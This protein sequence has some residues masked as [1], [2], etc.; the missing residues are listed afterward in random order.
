MANDK[1]AEGKE[2]LMNKNEKPGCFQEHMWEGWRKFVF[3]GAV[4]GAVVVV[5][6]LVGKKPEDAAVECSNQDLIDAYDA[7]AELCEDD[8]CREAMGEAI[9]CIPVVEEEVA[10]DV[11][12][13]V[14]ETV[15][16]EEEEVVEEADPVEEEVVEEAD[17]VE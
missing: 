11:E 14:E 16:E 1:A 13:P 17:P 12:E 4:I 7:A 3:L 9:E 5:I 6:L 2:S 10:E 15:A 8:A